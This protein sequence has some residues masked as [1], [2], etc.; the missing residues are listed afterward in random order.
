MFQLQNITI[1]RHPIFGSAD[2]NFANCIDE[3]FDNIGN[4]TSVII[5][6]NGIGKSYLLRAIADIFRLLDVIINKPE[7]GQFPELKYHFAVKYFMDGHTY[8]V[9][10]LKQGLQR[11]RA[12]NMT[13]FTFKKDGRNAYSQEMQL[14]RT[15]IA[16]SMTIADKFP[17]PSAGIYK[18]RGVRSEKTPST[19]G[20]RTIVRKAV[21]GIMDSL[22]HKHTT[23]EEIAAILTELGFQP[24]LEIKYRIRYRDVFVRPDMNPD[25]LR[26]IYTN[27]KE[28]FQG[29]RGEVW[30]TKYYHTL[31]NYPDRI[32]EVCQFLRKCYELTESNTRNLIVYDVFDPNNTLVF[33]ADVIKILSNL[34]ILSFPEFKVYKNN[35]HQGYDFVESSSGETQQLCQFISIMSA[36]EDNS[37]VLIDEPEN[38][39]HPNWQMN[40][41]GW[42]QKIF[43]SYRSCH[44]L[45]ATHSHFLLTDMRPEWS[46]II[47]LNK[48]ENGLQNIAEGVNTFCWSTDD[49]LYR[50]FHVRNTRN[51][52]FEDDIMR[53]YTLIEDGKKSSKEA[54]EI[55]KVLNGYVLP[56][57]D[58]ILKLLDL[59]KDA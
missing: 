37:L 6:R 25:L 35:V 23:R 39:S 45:I 55:A 15:V 14:P 56:G 10:D 30:G 13:A 8:V 16:S 47:A 28:Y 48:T 4:A 19:T 27:W 40:Y 33:D 22:A 36:I 57:N 1:Q 26:D 34:D 41:I 52:A 59:M 11:V 44:F 43:K 50:V 32:N 7:E 12:D 54:K 17:T 2:I 24:R 9:S 18:Y 46:S 5:G 21:E 31:S 53:L 58:P 49:I 20:T 3:Q 38:S 29:R 51:R 42:L